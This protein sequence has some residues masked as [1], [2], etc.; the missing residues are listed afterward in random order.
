MRHYR[1]NHSIE[2]KSHQEDEDVLSSFQQLLGSRDGEQHE[3]LSKFQQLL[4]SQ[5][6]DDEGKPMAS[7]AGRVRTMAAQ[8]NALQKR[9]QVREDPVIS[10]IT[11]KSQ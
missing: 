8:L 7:L 2:D 11:T 10:I 1:T 5:E 9:T 6:V 4:A 3:R